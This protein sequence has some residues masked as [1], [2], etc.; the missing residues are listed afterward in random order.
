[1]ALHERGSSEVNPRKRALAKRYAL[2]FTPCEVAIRERNPTE[3]LS[4]QQATIKRHVF[5][6]LGMGIRCIGKF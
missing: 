4:L 2:K 6:L 5:D 1:M 3:S